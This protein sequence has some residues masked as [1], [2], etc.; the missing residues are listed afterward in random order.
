[1]KLKSISILTL[2]A[3]TLAAAP[4]HGAEIQDSTATFPGAK[5]AAADT[6]LSVQDMLLYAQQDEYLAKGEYAAIQRTFGTQR[7]FSNISRAEDTHISLLSPILE[8]YGVEAVTSDSLP[9]PVIPESLKSAY[10]IGVQAEIENIEM[11]ERFL[12]QDL[13]ADVESVFLRLMNASENHLKAFE[14]NFSRMK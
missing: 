11:Y 3:M 2:L 8:K 5:G 1:M 4:V 7:I 10:A 14:R 6:T 13:P 9:S 12:E